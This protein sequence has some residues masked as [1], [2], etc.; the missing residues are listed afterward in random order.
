MLNKK[1]MLNRILIGAAV[2]VVWVGMIL[3]NI[4]LPFYANDDRP[5]YISGR[6]INSLIICVLIVLAVFEMRRAF[7]TER[8]PCAFNWILWVYGLALGPAFMFFGLAG[9]AVCTLIV[10][11]CAV[12]TAIAKNRADSLVFVAFTI[13]YPGLLFTALLYINQIPG[14]SADLMNNLLTKYFHNGDVSWIGLE[15]SS[16]RD[17]TLPLNAIGLA[18]VFTVSTFTDTCAYFVGSMFGKHPLCKQISPKKTVEG[19][20]GGIVG[21]ALGALVVFLLFDLFAIFGP[22]FGLTYEGLGLSTTQIVI[23]YVVIGLLGPVATQVGDLLAS[24]VKRYCGIKDYSRILG[25]HGGIMDRCDGM[26][27]NATLVAVVFMFIL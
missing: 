9:T 27:L 14:T 11:V 17:Y 3:L 10:F 16:Y 7:G 21:G 24:M 22:Q 23:T 2:L 4:Y 18:L 8:I 13:V 5:S 20:I 26:L 6:A 1:S 15:I 19:A 25:E 12:I